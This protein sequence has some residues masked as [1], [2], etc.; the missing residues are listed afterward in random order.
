MLKTTIGILVNGGDAW[1]GLNALDTID[2]YLW[3]D[4]SP[5]TMTFWWI[6]EPYD[7]VIP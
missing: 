4:E 7:E 1:I 5:V 2:F 3:S 6:N